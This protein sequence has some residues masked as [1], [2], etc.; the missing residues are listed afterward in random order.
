MTVTLKFN[1]DES[2]FPLA[3]KPDDPF[4]DNFKLVVIAEVTAAQTFNLGIVVLWKGVAY[5]I[6]EEPLDFKETGTY[7]LPFVWASET[8]PT[9]GDFIQTFGE[10]IPKE[11]TEY[12]YSWMV[13]EVLDS[14]MSVHD[15]WPTSLLVEIVPFP[16]EKVI[17]GTGVAIGALGLGYVALKRR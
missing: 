14:M 10:D 7:K 12:S 15:E 9:I 17:L 4:D 3:G 2:Y 5:L 13:G 11:T 8:S 6:H 1:K 16:W